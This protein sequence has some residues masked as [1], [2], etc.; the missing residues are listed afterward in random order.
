MNRIVFIGLAG[1]LGGFLSWLV[2][3]P[4]AR[5]AITHGTHIGIHHFTYGSFYGWFS[6]GMLGAL[7][8]GILAAISSAHNSK[9]LIVT[10]RGIVGFC[11]GGVLGWLTDAGS[12][13]LMIW[14]LQDGR[15][16]ILLGIFGQF[17]W[18]LSV[19]LGLALALLISIGPTLARFWRIMAAGLVASAVQYIL[20]IILSPLA[21][22]FVV[23]RSGMDLTNIQVWQP[24]APDRL[25]ER[26]SVGL[27]LGLA[28]SAFEYVLAS[29]RVYLELGRN[30]GK[31]FRL[32]NGWNRIGS[33]E[34][35]EV[36]INDRAIPAQCAMI[37]SAKHQIL[38]KAMNPAIPISVNGMPVNDACVKSGDV[39]QIAGYRLHIGGKSAYSIPLPIGETRFSEPVPPLHQA[40]LT[41]P[42]RFVRQLR[43]ANGR[44]IQLEPGTY[45]IGRDPSCEIALPDEHTVSRNHA[46]LRVSEKTIQV[47]DLGSTNGTRVNGQTFVGDSFL[48]GGDLISV[49]EANLTLLALNG[50]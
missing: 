32:E 15:D 25:I 10:I 41:V 4:F 16:S 21:M 50:S 31:E 30:E 46:E 47:R 11:L 9:P 14:A 5:T 1:A 38:L 40:P 3:E 6:H 48:V 28:V 8:V 34:G 2:S 44:T 36:Y 49:G 17:F 18:S 7:I 37:H 35:S 24:F 23:A 13:K 33:A 19:C 22:M 39:V 12:D 42:V 43:F 45:R 27:I 29:V 26:M 20:N